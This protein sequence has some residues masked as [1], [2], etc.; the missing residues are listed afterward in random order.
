M[1]A[2]GRSAL[3]VAGAAA[4]A[5]IIAK[6]V[7]DIMG[8]DSG[9][10]P[11]RRR[12]LK[13]G[14]GPLTPGL[15]NASTL[16]FVNSTL[17]ALA[18]CN[19]LRDY[20]AQLP[21]SCALASDLADMLSDLNTRGER[22]LRSTSLL[23]RRAFGQEDAHE[24]VHALI[25]AVVDE[26]ERSQ[27]LG[28]ALLAADDHQTKQQQQDP[29]TRSNVPPPSSSSSSH[30]RQ[31][32]PMRSVYASELVCTVCHAAFPRRTSAVQILDL[33]LPSPG[34]SFA[35]LTDLLRHY[36]STETVSG[37]DCPSCSAIAELKSLA[38]LSADDT[39]QYKRE[40]ASLLLTL[41]PKLQSLILR[42]FPD[43]ALHGLDSSSS[44]DRVIDSPSQLRARTHIKQDFTKTLSI[45]QLPP[46]LV[47]H[48]NR[49]VV[50]PMG[51]AKSNMHVTFPEQLDAAPYCATEVQAIDGSALSFI[52]KEAG[53]WYTLVAVIAHYGTAQ[54][55]HFVTY[56]RRLPV[57]TGGADDEAAWVFASDATVRLAEQSEVMRV[58]PYMLFYERVAG[59]AGIAQSTDVD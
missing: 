10:A 47:I 17:Q 41:S 42:E 33:S 50:S 51:L 54:S 25:E 40:I 3:A 32:N 16:C 43:D 38:A 44:S 36:H 30:Y 57:G 11:R 13:G 5:L 48:I 37:V 24:Y 58:N 6:A 52:I 19:T 26:G 34:S 55:G 18:S 22:T 27:P 49:V 35:S 53:L 4:L 12:R 45:M 8:E 2:T 46:L 28:L 20:L 31:S 21:S 29:L 59:P 39:P 7:I 15:R 14:H 9:S 23:P 1:S 56:R